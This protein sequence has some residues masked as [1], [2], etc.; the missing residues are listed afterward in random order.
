M[1]YPN[2]SIQDGLNRIALENLDVALSAPLGKDNAVVERPMS[3]ERDTA[4]GLPT[5]PGCSM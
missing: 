3:Y 5:E 2:G 4:S 1:T